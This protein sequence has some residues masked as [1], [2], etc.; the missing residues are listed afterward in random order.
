MFSLLGLPEA[1]I[2]AP[3]GCCGAH[4]AFSHVSLHLHSFSS[5]LPTH[6]PLKMGMWGIALGGE[7]LCQ[8]SLESTEGAET[9]GRGEKRDRVS[10]VMPLGF[11]FTSIS[12]VLET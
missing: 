3:P 9:P 2:G 6:A 8:T 12:R 1:E 5:P 10:G 4:S 7:E 11:T